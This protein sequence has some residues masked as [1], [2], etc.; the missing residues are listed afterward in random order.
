[1]HKDA[2]QQTDNAEKQ[3]A[4]ATQQHINADKVDAKAEKLDAFGGELED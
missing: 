3:K 2:A 1:M 4:I